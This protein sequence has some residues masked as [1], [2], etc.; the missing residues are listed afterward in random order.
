MMLFVATGLN[1]LDRQVLSITIIKIQQEFNISNIQYGFI[2]TSFLI[3]YGLM[4]TIGGRITE[5]FGAKIGMGFSVGIWSV[6]CVLHGF[7]ESFYHLLMVRFLLGIGEGGCFPGAAKAVNELFEKK[8]HAFAN[9]VS[10]GGSAIGAVLA[11]PLTIL[12]SNLYGWRWGFIIPGVIGLVWLAIWVVIP[13]TKSIHYSPSS[14]VVGSKRSLMSILKNKATLG[15]LL[16]RFLLDPVFYFIMF[17]IPKYLNEEKGISF[18]EIGKI[19]WIPFLA[20]GL[21]NIAG[22]WLSDLL[23]RKGVTINRARKYLMGIAALMTMV[24]VFIQGASSVHMAVGLMSMVMLGHGLWITNYITAISDVFGSDGTSTVIGL[25]GTAG[26]LAGLTLN[27]LIGY[28]IGNFGYQPLWLIC[29]LMYPIAF[30]LL[31][32]VVKRIGPSPLTF[33]AVP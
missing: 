20:L 30:V 8:N 7:T 14:S 10:I 28:A 11:P 29:G 1:F 17:W 5:K 33:T 6:A 15:F 25:S 26:A 9:G 24:A 31:L 27:P 23:V 4:F 32:V 18:T 3:S 12:I 16:I 19:L 2:N 21:S 22:G 13:W